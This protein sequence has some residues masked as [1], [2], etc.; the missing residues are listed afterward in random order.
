MT[1]RNYSIMH[2]TDFS[3]LSGMAFL[4]A[5]RISL[6]LKAKLY[7]LHV[8]DGADEDPWH[9]FPHVRQTLARWG[10]FDENEPP[11]ELIPRLGLEVLKVEVEPQDPVIGFSHFFL[12]H[13]TDLVVLATHGREGLPRWL[14]P[15]IAEAMFRRSATPTLF[16]SAHGRGFVDQGT[17]ATKLDRILVPVDHDPPAAAALRAVRAFRRTLESKEA[18]INL[19]H[20]GAQAPALEADPEPRSPVSVELRDGN[21]VDGILQAADAMN[22]DLIAM[23]TRGHQGLLDVLRGSVTEQV[24][25]RARCPILAV[26]VLHRR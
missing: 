20:V 5:L 24:L 17:G 19:L 10:L 6:A 15:S 3:D 26:P 23:A 13:R 2:P 14:R 25:R 1:S 9:S 18:E 8:A 16:I 12:Q 21:V 7:L 4:H 22:A 11:S